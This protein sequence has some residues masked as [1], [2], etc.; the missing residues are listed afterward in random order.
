MAPGVVVIGTGTSFEAYSADTGALL[1]T[2]T[3]STANSA[4]TGSA[5]IANGQILYGN[6]DGILVAVGT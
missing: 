5:S 2:Y 1:Y 4:F 6:R 3:D